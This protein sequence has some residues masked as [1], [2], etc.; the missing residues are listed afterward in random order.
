MKSSND[1]RN[2]AR[3]ENAMFVTSLTMLASDET[4]NGSSLCR[5]CGAVLAAGDLA[6]EVCETSDA[7]WVTLARFFCSRRCAGREMLFLRRRQWGVEEAQGFVRL[8]G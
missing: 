4:H 2:T 3:E 6:Y 7:R 1:N 5:E 8:V